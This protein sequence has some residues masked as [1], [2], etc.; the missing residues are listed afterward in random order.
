MISMRVC[1]IYGYMASLSHKTTLLLSE[2]DYD[3]LVRESRKAGQTLG[4][5]I[6][7]AIRKVYSAPSPRRAKKAWKKLFAAKAPVDDWEKMEKE[8]IR[9]R[10]L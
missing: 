4:E 1:H 10:L 5:L 8:I 2:E 3:T 9:G 6:R 7:L